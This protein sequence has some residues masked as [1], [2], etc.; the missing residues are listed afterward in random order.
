MFNLTNPQRRLNA[1]F[2][3]S[4]PMIQK[5]WTIDMGAQAFPR[6]SNS[7]FPMLTFI[8]KSAHASQTLILTN[9]TQPALPVS[10][11]V[12]CRYTKS[13]QLFEFLCLLDIMRTW[14]RLRPKLPA[15]ALLAWPCGTP[16]GTLV[17]QTSE[18]D[19]VL[20]RQNCRRKQTKPG[21]LYFRGFRLYLLSP[22]FWGSQVSCG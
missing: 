22:W 3:F 17:Q 4:D 2:C 6:E 10:T 9:K 18:E 16:C 21:L 5:M 7:I 12:Q 15:I 1:Y 19:G 20:M 8:N 14:K 11:H 13:T